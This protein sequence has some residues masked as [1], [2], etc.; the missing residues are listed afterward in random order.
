MRRLHLLGRVGSSFRRYV[1]DQDL[2]VVYDD[3]V[4]R[5]RALQLSPL[6][7][8]TLLAMNGSQSFRLRLI[9]DSGLALVASQGQ[10]VE[11]Q[12]DLG[13]GLLP[14]QLS[15]SRLVSPRLV[16]RRLFRGS[17]AL[18]GRLSIME[19]RSSVDLRGARPRCSRPAAKR[20]ALG[21]LVT[22]I[23]MIVGIASWYHL[24]SLL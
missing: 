2:Q 24:V 15:I 18:A 14:R 9:S 6:L 10:D 1:I 17:G 11:L 23:F 16:A 21:L 7:P 13:C 3:F 4:D 8:L 19:L 20:Q 5:G 22:R 12:P